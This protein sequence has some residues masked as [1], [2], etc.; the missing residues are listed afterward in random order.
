MRNLFLA[1]AALLGLVAAPAFA[2]TAP[3]PSA[4][5]RPAIAPKLPAP[6]LEENASPR[7]FLESAQ[8]ALA[9]H[10]IGEA[11]EALERAETRMLDRS[12]VPSRADIPDTSAGVEQIRQARDA[13]ARRD[14]RGAQQIIASALA[15][16]AG[17]AT[18]SG[19]APGTTAPPSGPPPAS[20]TSGPASPPANAPAGPAM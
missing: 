7:A 14:L 11:Q 10:R 2:Q 13:L 19:A 9:Q 15:A 17:A 5:D 8:Q 3:A 4:S 18:P 12:V 6:P 20:P 16:S 1:S